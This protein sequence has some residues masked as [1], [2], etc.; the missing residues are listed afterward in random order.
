MTDT[1]AAHLNI[2][3]LNHLHHS[4]FI[5]RRHALSHKHIQSLFVAL[6]FCSRR[7]FFGAR[8]PQN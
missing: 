3:T 7:K 5:Q 4:R 6:N 2:S 8:E 1:R